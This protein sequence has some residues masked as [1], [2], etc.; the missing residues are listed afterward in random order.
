MTL[1]KETVVFVSEEAKKEWTPPAKAKKSG[2]P[3]CEI[4]KTTGETEEKK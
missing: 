1:G 3:N 4:T 2:C